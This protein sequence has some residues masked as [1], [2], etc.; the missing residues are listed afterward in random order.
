[1]SL[2]HPSKKRKLSPPGDS[3]DVV[4]QE[5]YGN[6]AQWNLE[7]S[8]EDRARKQKKKDK[9]SDKLPIKTSEG[10]VEHAQKQ[11]EEDVVDESEGY[12]SA[13][14]NGT[15][16]QDEEIVEE[17]EDKRPLKEQVLEAKEELARIAGLISEDPEEN[18]GLLKNLAKIGS[19]KH[20]PI[21]LLAMATQVAVYKDIIPGYRIR[22]LSEEDLKGKLSKDVKRLRNFEQTLVVSYQDYINML[23]RMA[24]RTPR[25]GDVQS[26]SALRSTALSCACTLVTA[27]PHFNIRKDLFN[28]LV[29]KVASREVGDNTVRCNAALTAL[30]ENDDDGNASLEAVTLL[31]KMFK[32]KDFNI[33]E[34]TLNTFLSLR[35]LSEYSYRASTE[36]IDKEDD[37]GEAP[38]FVKKQKREFRTKKLRKTLREEK[39]IQKEMKEADAVVGHEE[40]DKNQSEMLKMVFVAYFRI[41]KMRKNNLMGAVL[42]GLARYAHLINQDFFGDILEALRDLIAQQDGQ[43]E[44]LTEGLDDETTQRDKSR[45]SLLCIV[46]AFSLLQGQDIHKSATALHLDLSFFTKKLYNTILPLSLDAGTETASKSIKQSSNMSAHAINVQTP[47]LLLFRSLNALL[48]PAQST[49]SVPPVLVASFVR[50]LLTSALNLPE[51]STMAIL[52]LVKQVVRVHGGKISAIWYSEERRGDGVFDMTRADFESSNPFAGTCWEGELLRLHWSEKV[53]HALTEIEE[54]IKKSRS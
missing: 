10:R 6:A 42:E 26:N 54:S 47:S 28:I 32:A 20:T 23:A 48:L 37:T 38:S 24:K 40:R 29:T 1:M 11:S 36:R 9:K 51:K 19:S 44:E 39:E 15:D 4:T 27:V 5:Y 22:P 12:D 2:D 7:Q 17:V 53:R 14:E 25:D 46:T 3:V 43:D 52:G 21:K 18:I 8:Y 34:S 33:H 30:F 16:E 41:L 50:R 45:E 13:N 31:T 35:L 49:R